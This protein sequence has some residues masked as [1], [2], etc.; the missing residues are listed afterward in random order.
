MPL[1]KIWTPTN[2]YPTFNSKKTRIIIPQPVD[3]PIELFAKDV[4]RDELLHESPWWY[5]LHTRGISRPIL[6]GDP[7]E[8][9]AVPHNQVLGTL[10]ERIVYFYLVYH[11]HMTSGIEFDF[12]SS[13]Q[14]G[15]TE[16][17]G[18]VADF[19]FPYLRLVIQVQGQTHN[20]F[21]QHKKDQQQ[22]DILAEMGYYV[23][24]IWEEDIYDEY[25]FEEIMRRIF[26]LASSVGG[27]YGYTVDNTFE[28]IDEEND[29]RWDDALVLAKGIRAN[30]LGV[31]PT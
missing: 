14:G 10:P 29:K 20:G 9:R 19:L 7:R 26:N 25:R 8:S 2:Y 16:L 18:M 31:Y 4:I 3:R 12:Q 24:A 22:T 17:G 21:L 6:G 13:Q 11:L 15:R 1:K 28:K 27:T 23:E 5:R 30:L